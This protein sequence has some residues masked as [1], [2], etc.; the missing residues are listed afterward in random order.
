MT[1]SHYANNYIYSQYTIIHNFTIY[2]GTMN[3][4][5]TD[6][7]VGMCHLNINATSQ[8]CILWF[9]NLKKYYKVVYD[10]IL[11]MYVV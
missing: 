3:I 1:H 5:A 2:D 11:N 9:K 7:T 8:V 10:S 4:H 6:N